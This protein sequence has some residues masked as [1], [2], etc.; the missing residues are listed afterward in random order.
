MKTIK[1]YSLK[2]NNKLSI[3]STVFDNA[4]YGK[5]VR[6]EPDTGKVIT[7]GVKQ[8]SDITCKVESANAFQEIEGEINETE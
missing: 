4:E 5:F 6:L 2:T 1:L 8:Y 7:D 3:S